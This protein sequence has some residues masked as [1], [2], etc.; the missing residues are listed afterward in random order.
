MAKHLNIEPI[1]LLEKQLGLLD[2]RSNWMWAL[3]ALLLVLQGFAIVML[4]LPQFRIGGIPITAPE[5]HGILAT[6]LIGLTLLFALYTT[7]R[8]LSLRKMRSTMEEERLHLAS[9]R[10]RLNELSELFEV[11]T[12]MGTHV[13]EKSYLETVTERLQVALDANS[14]MIFRWSAEQ[15]KLRCEYTSGGAP[16]YTAGSLAIAT[17]DV[18]LMVSTIREPRVWDRS[19][20]DRQSPKLSDHAPDIVSLVCVPLI[21]RDRREGAI[22][23][24]RRSPGKTFHEEESLLLAR[25]SDFLAEDIRK[26][27]RLESLVQRN[28]DLEG[29]N[30]RLHEL[31]DL[32]SVFLSTVKNEIRSPLAE[33]AYHAEQLSST[34]PNEIS[35]DK[36]ASL[37]ALS[38]GDLPS[39]RLRKRDRRAPFARVSD[40]PCPARGVCAE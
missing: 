40:G 10:I 34:K 30:Q 11:A 12:R 31:T 8:H 19:E 25:F 35:G 36:D 37:D 20:I 28:E 16:P 4:Y 7:E 15:S 23:A 26:V 22:L 32:K 3:G 17:E 33:I 1:A 38:G 13:D 21:E 39:W 6:S 27:R 14:V 9:A 29:A 2:K 18:P 5:S 24:I